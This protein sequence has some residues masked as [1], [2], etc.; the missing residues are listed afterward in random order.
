MTFQFIGKKCGRQSNENN[1]K[2]MIVL[3]FDIETGPLPWEQLE[4][5]MPDLDESEFQVGEFD[6]SSVKLGNLKD[7]AKIDAKID[8][9]RKKHEQDAATVAE[10]IAAAREK[11]QQELVE[12]AAL[13]AVTGRV[14]AI[15]VLA[16][17]SGNFV[18]I[19]GE[20][21]T[22]LDTFWR[23]V[24]DCKKNGR[25]LVGHNIAGFDIPF[26]I[27]RSWLN[28]ID[29]PQGLYERGKWLNDRLFV[30]TMSTWT[31]GQYGK[32]ISLDSL[33]RA[34]AVGGKPEDVSG[35]DFARL[36]LGSPEERQKATEYL[37]NDLKLTAA[38]AVGMGL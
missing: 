36:W 15:G 32:G 35:K 22:I 25:K 8:E 3:I 33:G 12:G 7:Q 19:E 13:N 28:G 21:H 26:L 14:L 5:W 6:S 27:Q 4:A 24:E 20:E 10:R 2:E 38:V 18:V 17:E 31:C 9:A 34:F 23:K 37:I 1:R 30:D 29:V 11:Q 16:A